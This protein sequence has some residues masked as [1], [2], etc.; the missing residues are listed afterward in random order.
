MSGF[1]G[2]YGETVITA[3]CGSAVTG[4]IPVSPPSESFLL[5]TAEITAGGYLLFFR[6]SI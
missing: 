5:L 2:D 4:S 6:K 1:N 3:L